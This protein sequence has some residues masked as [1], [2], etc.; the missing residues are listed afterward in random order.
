MCNVLLCTHSTLADGFRSAVMMIARSA[1]SLEILCFNDGCSMETLMEQIIT[2]TEHFR[3]Q[4]ESYCIVTDLFGAS[5]FNAAMQ[6][7]W[8]DQVS[9]VT[10]VNLALLLELLNLPQADAT[11]ENI[12]NLII[13]ARDQIRCYNPAAMMRFSEE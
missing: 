9:I 2:K 12:E 5:P 4:N 13:S 6:V 7:C 3:Q 8:K 10:G 11:I 1:S